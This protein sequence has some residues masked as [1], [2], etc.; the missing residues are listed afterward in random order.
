MENSIGESEFLDSFAGESFFGILF[1][2][3]KEKYEER[4][5]LKKRF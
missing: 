5:C 1:F 4:I 3:D 2:A